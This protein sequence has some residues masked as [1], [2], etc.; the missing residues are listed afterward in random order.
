[1]IL[2]LLNI[3]KM[4]ATHWDNIEVILVTDEKFEENFED[5]FVNMLTYVNS[6]RRDCVTGWNLAASKATGDMFVQVS[7]DLFPPEQWD[8]KLISIAGNAE[9]FSL[10]LPD[11]RGLRDCVMHP[12]ISRTVYEH[13]GYLYPADFKSVYCD[14]WLYC[15]HRQA[16]FLQSINEGQFWNH[17]HRT[18]HNVVVDDV[19]LRHES[20]E[21]YVEGHLVFVRELQ[22]LGITINDPP[23]KNPAQ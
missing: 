3:W 2:G 8:E 23:E 4:R 11:E 15:A 5:Q 10:Q 21:R 18:T 13:F 16:G 22:K 17:V 6:G 12:V 1:L 14:D 19:L 20:R 9:Y 7:D